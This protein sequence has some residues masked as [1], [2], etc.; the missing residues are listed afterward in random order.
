MKRLLRENLEH[1]DLARLVHDE[2]HFDE[3]KSKLGDDKDVIVASFKVAGKEPALDIV[4]FVE[5]GYDF[6]LDADV[7]SGEMN[8]G[9]FIVFVELERSKQAPEQIMD[10][11][12]G[13]MNLTGQ[14]TTDFRV[15][16]QH[17]QEDNALDIDSLAKLIPLDPTEYERRFGKEDED[18]DKKDDDEMQ[19][20]L[21]K[22]R[23]AAGI[24]SKVR[25]PDNEHT[26]QLRIAAG[27]K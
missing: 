11:M 14:E 8:D 27:L 22:I 1:G 25:A 3:F 18:D 19:K 23:A 7:S 9:D 6:V 17:G 12:T 21:D 10:I 4:N 15:R 13:V 24:K 2:I 20:Q 26:S 5:K 16:Y